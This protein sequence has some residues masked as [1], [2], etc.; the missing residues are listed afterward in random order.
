MFVL[1]IWCHGLL[2]A[3]RPE[4]WVQNWPN[5]GARRLGLGASR[6]GAG[7]PWVRND[8]IPLIITIS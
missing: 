6:L 3:G 5:V 2:G 7:G 1:D 8:W 4:G